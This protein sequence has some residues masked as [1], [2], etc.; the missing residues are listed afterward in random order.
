M[1]QS[2]KPL[3]VSSYSR[4]IVPNMIIKNPAFSLLLA[5]ILAAVLASCQ[6]TDEGQAIKDTLATVVKLTEKKNKEGIL[7]YLS[8]DYR[9]FEQRDITRT[10]ELIDYYFTDYRGI[11]IHLL[12]ISVSI[13]DG[14]AEVEVDVLLSSGPAETLR[15]LVSFAGSFYRFNFRFVRQ[16]RKWKIAYSAWQEIDSKSLLPGS[17][18]IIKKLFPDLIE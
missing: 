10:G 1:N 2:S 13:I 6:K 18:L 3:S 12:D 7:S 11:V 5:L 17:R 16:N 9:D 8:D 4:W 14:E 15:K